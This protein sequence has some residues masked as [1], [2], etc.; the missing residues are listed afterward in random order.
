VTDLV[1]A[2]HSFRRTLEKAKREL[3]L[4][5]YPYDSLASV[6]Q[7]APLLPRG[8]LLC[9]ASREFSGELDFNV[10][11]PLRIGGDNRI[12]GVLVSFWREGAETTDSNLPIE[13]E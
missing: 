5:W 3:A 10:E 12:L 11:P 6:P 4:D 13:V 8:T 1:S 7:I 2:A 9:S